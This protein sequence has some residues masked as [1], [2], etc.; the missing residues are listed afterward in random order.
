M[1][2]IGGKIMGAVGRRIKRIR[3]I[4]GWTQKELAS[5]LGMHEMTVQSYELGYRNP[6]Q[7]QIK[8]IAEALDIDPA[9]LQPAKLDTDNAIFALLFDLM[10]QYGD[11]KMEMKG[12]TVLFG[13]DSYDHF[14][15]NRKLS[16]AMKAHA[17]MSP[18]E[19]KEWLTD[20]PPL[21]HNGQ[22]IKRGKH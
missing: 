20:Y 21:L 6:K 18:D 16:D 22:V 3:E 8:R 7:D 4:R 11:I 2:S 5:I 1:R 12:G 13:I 10:E 15:E 17:N 14:S 19:F 9:F